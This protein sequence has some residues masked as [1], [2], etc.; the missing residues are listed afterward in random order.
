MG[1][2]GVTLGGSNLGHVGMVQYRWHAASSGAE[3]GDLSAAYTGIRQGR[4]VAV[5]AEPYLVVRCWGLWG[6]CHVGYL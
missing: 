2:R 3:L 6:E 4:G 5:L 1:P